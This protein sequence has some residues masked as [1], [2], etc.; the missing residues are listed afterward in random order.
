VVG[1]GVRPVGTGDGPVGHGV[2]PVGAGEGTGVVGTS[3]VALSW[4]VA[5]W[6]GSGHDDCWPA[7]LGLCV[8]AIVPVVAPAS[9]RQ[10]LQIRS[11]TWPVLALT[12]KAQRNSDSSASVQS[13]G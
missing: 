2:G 8:G 10:P 1:A 3:V 4:H 11:A 13:F 12:M 5:H 9:G 6:H 7:G